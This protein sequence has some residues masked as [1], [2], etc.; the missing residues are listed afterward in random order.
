MTTS[1]ER[2]LQHLGY[3]DEGGTYWKPPLGEKSYLDYDELR[4]QHIKVSMQ[5]V[6]AL[7]ELR[8]INELLDSIKMPKAPDTIQRVEIVVQY[9]RTAA[10]TIQSGIRTLGGLQV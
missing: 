3:T 5:A 9:L 4:D 8:M 7:A 1:A 10:T 6:T 2:T